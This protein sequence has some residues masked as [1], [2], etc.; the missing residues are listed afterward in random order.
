MKMQVICKE[1]G[2]KRMAAGNMVSILDASKRKG[3]VINHSKKEYTEIDFS[4][5]ELNE[6]SKYDFFER[7]RTL[8]AQASEILGEKE[9]NGR[10]TIGYRI[11]EKGMNFIFW[12]D[13]DSRDLVLSELKFVNAPGIYAVI[14]DF[15]FDI[16]ADDSLF[17][18]KPPEGYI[19]R[20]IDVDRT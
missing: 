16:E 9:I 6:P 4:S 10:K 8:P 1:H 17:S 11:L 12:L 19:Q 18:L 13:I 15:R 3:I 5:Q 20:N 2:Y 7:M 14:S